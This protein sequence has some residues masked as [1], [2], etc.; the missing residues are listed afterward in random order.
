M[1]SK[2]ASPK[3]FK[4]HENVFVLADG[5][6][7]E[8]VVESAKKHELKIQVWGDEEAHPWPGHWLECRKPTAEE[9]QMIKHRA[10]VIKKFKAGDT[11][12]ALA[13]NTRWAAA[14]VLVKDSNY[15][16][17]K[18]ESFSYAPASFPG[19][20][21]DV[22]EKNAKDRQFEKERLERVSRAAVGTRLKVL[23]EG[24]WFNGVV[25]KNAGGQCFVQKDGEKDSFPCPGD[26]E[27]I[28]FFTEQERKAYEAKREAELR[29]QS[30]QAAMANSQ[31][32][33]EQLYRDRL[34]FS[35]KIHGEQHKQTFVAM[36]N[37]AAYLFEK[38][39]TS[40]EALQLVEACRKVWAEN[41]KFASP[42]KAK[43]AGKQLVHMWEAIG[44]EENVAK[45]AE[46]RELCGMKQIIVKTDKAPE[47]AKGDL[48]GGLAAALA[49][50]AKL[51]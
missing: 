38:D 18:T 29:E 13:P 42:D 6:W 9:L 7:I 49:S 11:V 35:Q 17:L 26:F 32:D 27:D 45:A 39:L 41:P 8:G 14:K 31:M 48:M 28:K 40:I 24:I 1:A 21:L 33:P 30:R 34:E 20:W 51:Q 19:F 37:L 22:R 50:R 15:L 4:K 43:M 46:M 10:S 12:M 16:L 3:D 47:V 23:D 25:T 44:G 2:G 5:M 36:W